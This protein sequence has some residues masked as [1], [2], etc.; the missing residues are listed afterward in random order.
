MSDAPD[1]EVEEVESAPEAPAEEIEAKESPAKE[2]PEVTSEEIELEPAQ[3]AQMLGLDEDD[4]SVDEA[5]GIQVHAKV[6]GKPAQV[7]LRDL[8]HSYQLA[9]THEERLRELGRERKAFQEQSQAILQRLGEQQGQME[10][11]VQ[12]LEEEYAADFQAVDWNTLRLE[13]PTEYNA[14]RIDYEDKRR[15]IGEYRARAQYQAQQLQQQY[16]GK[17]AEA[18]SDGA[19]QLAEVFDGSSYRNAP[20]WDAQESE[21]LAKWIM[22]QGFS[23]QDVSSVGV[24]QVFKWARDSMLREQELRNAQETVKKVA[25][26][27]KVTKPGK[28]KGAKEV[29]T[30]K[31]KN[32]KARQKKAGG[33]LRETTELISELFRS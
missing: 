30:A 23:A 20:K 14:K 24:W 31:V 21:K 9:S 27:P 6:D 1:I 16:Q 18:Q 5:G 4:I 15:R 13:D 28:P 25:K 17:L 33:H 2:E 12:A 7:S 10:Q 8:R 26:M 22:D 19:R 32:L 29:Q 11:A 3:V